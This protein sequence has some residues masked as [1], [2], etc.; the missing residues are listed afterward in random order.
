MV[1]LELGDVLGDNLVASKLYTILLAVNRTYLP[2]RLCYALA[3]IADVSA[4]K[5]YVQ[6]GTGGKPLVG[7]HQRTAFQVEVLTITCLGNT[8][9]QTLLKVSG[10]DGLIEYFLLLGYIEQPCPDGFAIVFNLTHSFSAIYCSRILL[11]L[12]LSA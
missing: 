5:V 6:C 2:E 11:T 1:I 9:Q 3:I 12:S 4:K 8:I 10:Q 7:V